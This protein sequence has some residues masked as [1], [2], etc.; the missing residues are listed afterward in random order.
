MNGNPNTTQCFACGTRHAT[1]DACPSVSGA[2]VGTVLEG[3]YELVRLLGQGGM[4]EVYEGRHRV[5][6]RRVAVKF[7][8]AEYA[9]HPEVAVRFENEA[10]AA[11]GTE[12]ENIGGV[13]DVGALPDRTKYLVMEFLDGEDVDKLVQR[14]APLPVARAAFIV[15]Q[16]C[17]GLDVVHQR[18][19]VHR[20]LKPA[21]LF[22]ARRGDKTDLVKVLDFGIA[23]LREADALGGTK[24]GAAIGTASYMSP[25]QARGQ[26]DVDSRSDVYSLGVILY[27]LLSGKKPHAGDSLL[28]ILHKVM[29]QPPIALE[30]VRAG[31]PVEM[32]GVV[33]RAMA[34]NP[35]DRYQTVAELGD[36]LLPFA[37]RA[38]PAIRSQPGAGFAAPLASAKETRGTA[39]S[40]VDVAGRQTGASVVGVAGSK[41]TMPRDPGPASQSRSRAIIAAGL[42]AALTATILAAIAFSRSRGH[43]SEASQG[44]PAR[45]LVSGPASDAIAAPPAPTVTV[46]VAPPP[47]IVTPPPAPVATVPTPVR[48]SGHRT[49]SGQ[50]P[51]T[52][53][54]SASASK[55]APAPPQAAAT[56]AP[57]AA[58]VPP[59]APPNP[60]ATDRGANPF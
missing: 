35:A 26:R 21:N 27:E 6:G 9:K 59:P 23:K 53:T 30:R 22:L 55:P 58:P 50:S 2:R 56:A 47:S 38:L 29:T 46:E 57:I 31:L 33:R 12:H 28:Q 32:Y 43:G 52:P 54:V 7:L 49:L 13:Y 60:A 19:I 34:S 20:D 14:E 5:I 44:E 51:V 1:T 36:S 24:T 48:P 16:A 10:R 15:I 39:P 11:G 3:K 45:T 37:G 41:P 25:E 42:V 17:R 8:L 18:G 4:G 40:A